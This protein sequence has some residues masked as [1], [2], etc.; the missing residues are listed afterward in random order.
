MQ[1]EPFV[2]QAAKEGAEV[3]GEPFGSGFRLLHEIHLVKSSVFEF[4]F[5]FIKLQLI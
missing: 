3:D 1:D 4:V 2:S 5:D